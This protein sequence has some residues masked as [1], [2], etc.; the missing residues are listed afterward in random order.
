[1]RVS[2][3]SS[4][5]Q[6]Q[7][8]VGGESTINTFNMLNNPA[9]PTHSLQ[10]FAKVLSLDIINVKYVKVFQ[11]VCNMFELLNSPKV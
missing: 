7:V 9:S 10:S 2:S 6:I 1:M 11:A 4:G 3:V 5:S 8:L